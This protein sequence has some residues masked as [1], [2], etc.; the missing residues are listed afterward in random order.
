[1]NSW[2]SDCSA[3]CSILQNIVFTNLQ[4]EMKHADCGFKDWLVKTLFLKDEK[5]SIFFIGNGASA[6]MASHFAADICKNVRI[7]TQVFTD[8]ALITAISNDNSYSEVYSLPISHYAE[9]GDM[10][11]AISSSGNSPN[12]VQ[13]V[14]AALGKGLEVVTLSGMGETNRIRAMGH[15][16]IYVPA[17]TYGLVETAHAAIL[18]YW[19]DMMIDK[20]MV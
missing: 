4:G 17:N 14:E 10:L 7:R 15:L 12:I 20:S 1:M 5:R 9:P 8:S 13:G 18:H 6:T 16:N 3:F 2:N 19:T 11:V